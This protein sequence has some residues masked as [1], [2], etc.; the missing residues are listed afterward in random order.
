M[1]EPVVIDLLRHGEVESEQWAFRG[2]TD[3]HLSHRGMAQMQAVGAALDGVELCRIGAS[4]LARCRLFAEPMTRSRGISLDILPDMREMDFGDWEG[5]GSDAVDTEL[6][7]QFRISPSGFQAPHGE[8]FDA[9]S[10]R[11]IRCWKA[12]IADAN[13]ERR[14]L[15][16]HGGVLRVLLAWLLGMPDAHVWRLHLP[17]ASWSR[18]S[19]LEGEQPRLLFL[20]REPL[21]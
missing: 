4:P 7:R 16:T 19:L 8:A 6:L 20:N 5:K 1:P 12:W 13:A 17:Y 11:V 3:V 9:F 15:V 14:M 21:P 10:V 2:S 18:V